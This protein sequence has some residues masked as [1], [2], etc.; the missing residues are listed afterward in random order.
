MPG[1]RNARLPVR[2]ERSPRLPQEGKR[3]PECRERYTTTTGPFGRPILHCSA[4]CEADKRRVHGRR[5]YT[6]SL[7]G[8]AEPSL[9]RS[10]LPNDR[11]GKGGTLDPATE[12]PSHGAPEP[13]ICV[14]IPGLAKVGCGG[15]E[16]LDS[17]VSLN[18]QGARACFR[19]AQCGRDRWVL[20][21]PLHDASASLVR[22]KKR[23]LDA[24]SRREF[25]PEHVLDGFADAAH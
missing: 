15:Q 6:D 1:S 19:C 12:P 2:G 16:R 11:V 14:T 17:T 20:L 13:G 21:A 3:C 22:Y 9:Y 24:Y 4:E 5:R 10:L 18:F 23:W 25:L 8:K 7:A